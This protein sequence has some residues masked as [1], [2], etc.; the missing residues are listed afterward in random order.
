MCYVICNGSGNKLYTVMQVMF[1]VC[2]G[3]YVNVLL[4]QY[5]Q[6]GSE[7]CACYQHACIKT[8]LGIF[9]EHFRPAVLLSDLRFSQ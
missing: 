6:I 8:V 9:K 1:E 5:V 4:A 7:E 2:N 3:E